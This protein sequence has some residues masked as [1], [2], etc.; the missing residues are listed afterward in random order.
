VRIYWG[1]RSRGVSIPIS[2]RGEFTLLWTSNQ[3]HQQLAPL[4]QPGPKAGNRTKYELN[5]ARFN[6][7]TKQA[8]VVLLGLGLH[9]QG[10]NPSQIRI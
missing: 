10:S 2:G 8:H 7:P 4:V 6:S 9:Y 1:V 5:Q 3:T